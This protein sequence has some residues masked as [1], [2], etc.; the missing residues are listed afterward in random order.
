M[1]LNS[2]LVYIWPGTS[3]N[4]DF[5]IWRHYRGNILKCTM[6]QNSFYLTLAISNSVVAHIIITLA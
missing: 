2:I 1:L 4:Y 6:L 3:S 5:S